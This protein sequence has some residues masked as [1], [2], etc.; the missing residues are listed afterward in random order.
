ANNDYNECVNMIIKTTQSHDGL[1]YFISNACLH[2]SGGDDNLIEII[3]DNLSL[4]NYR[5]I[6]YSGFKL[7]ISSIKTI[8]EFTKFMKRDVNCFNPEFKK[9][10]LHCLLSSKNFF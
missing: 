4:S 9:Y 1:E 5:L 7:Y 10:T 6:P 3:F 2:Y 8:K